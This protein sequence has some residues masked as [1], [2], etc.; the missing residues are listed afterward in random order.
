MSWSRLDTLRNRLVLLL[1]AC[2]V[3]L[4][5]GRL[6]QLCLPFRHRPIL[7]PELGLR[8]PPELSPHL[9]EGWSSFPSDHAA[10]FFAFSTGIYLIAPSLGLLATAHTIGMICFPRLYLGLH[11][12]TDLL[13]G[14]FIGVAST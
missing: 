6:L 1:G 12:A 4:S 5:I 8:I 7:T 14:A 3:A 10:L 9:F 2:L 11:F 13:A